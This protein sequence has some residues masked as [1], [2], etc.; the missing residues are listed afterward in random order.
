MIL[1]A[2]QEHF[3]DPGLCAAAAG[4]AL[5]RPLATDRMP[6]IHDV[7]VTARLPVSLSS[8]VSLP[9]IVYDTTTYMTYIA[10]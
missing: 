4:G 10:I 5:C 7:P 2:L 3:M 9:T 6:G 8:S 1:D